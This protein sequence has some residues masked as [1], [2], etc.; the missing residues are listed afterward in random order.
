M[1]QESCECAD[2]RLRWVWGPEGRMT[3][4]LSMYT[5]TSGWGLGG[6]MMESGTPVPLLF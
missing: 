1:R 4:Q 6:V 2:Q 3:A 5:V